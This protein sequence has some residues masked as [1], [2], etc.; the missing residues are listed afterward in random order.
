M[1]IAK[2]GRV[3]LTWG[4]FTARAGF[5]FQCK[6]TPAVAPRGPG[7]CVVALD[8]TTTKPLHA[9]RR[10]DSF[11]IASWPGPT[12]ASLVAGSVTARLGWDEQGGQPF[13]VYAQN[14]LTWRQL[15]FEDARSITIKRRMSETM[16]LG[17]MG[18][19][20]G[21]FWSGTTRRTAAMWEALVGVNPDT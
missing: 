10:P 1:A 9:A 12:I 8:P 18:V 15:W 5:D 2:A 16:Q 7:D 14:N 17:G 4:E 3:K 20:L 11:A 6:P 21:D 19:F 13:L